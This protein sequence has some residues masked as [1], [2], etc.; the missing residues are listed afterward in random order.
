MSGTFAIQRSDNDGPNLF[1][2]VD[3]Q[4]AAGH[5]H[6]ISWVHRFT[7]RM[8]GTSKYQYT[9]W[10]QRM[11]PYFA[12]VRNISGEAGITGNNQEPQNWGPP[13]LSF[14]SGI[15]GLFDGAAVLHPQP[16]QRGRLRPLLEPRPAQLHV[17]R[18]FPAAAV[19]RRS[20]SR[21]RAARFTFTGPLTGSDFADF[22]LGVPTPARSPSATPTSTSARQYVR[23]LLHRRLA[24]ELGL[25]LERRRPLGIRLA[26]HRSG[27]AAW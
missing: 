25:H 7:N 14:A 26:D 11:T 18:R 16:D 4:G 15:A 13:R 21:T 20:R 9:R 23:R 24:D 10:S 6:L 27:T 17:R 12:N 5:R 8:F 2:F 3:T 22:L 1:G 19:Q